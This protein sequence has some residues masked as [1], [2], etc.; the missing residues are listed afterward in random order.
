MK[1]KWC[2]ISW[3]LLG[4]YTGVD[5]IAILKPVDAET[6][7]AKIL[8]LNEIERPKTRASF[9]LGQA[10]S[11][12][13]R[14][15]VNPPLLTDD[16]SDDEDEEE[17]IVEGERTPT[18]S[19]P[20]Y[21][22]TSDEIQQQGSRSVTEVLRG[23]PGFAVNDTGF[24]ADIHTGLYYRGTTLNQ[25]VFLLNGRPIGSNVSTYHGAT[26]L[27][28]LLVGDIDRIELSSGTAST[29]YGSNAFGGVVDIITKDYEGPLKVNALAQFGSYGQQNYRAGI[30]GSINTLSYAFGYERF[31]ADND[32]RVPVGAAN[33]GPDGRLF[34]GDV[35]FENY[36]G[37]LALRID[38]RNT[39]SL[40]A[41]KI[42]SRKGLLYFGFPLQ[43][44]RLNHDA[45]NIGL[46]WKG[47]VGANNDSFI[48]AFLAFNR[49]YFDT[50]GPTRNIFFRE[51]QLDSR[52]LTG[53][54]EH[55]WQVAPALNLRYGVDLQSDFLKGNTLSNV[56]R[57]IRFNEVEERD[58]FNAALFLLNTWKITDTLQ[59]E[60]GLRQNFNTE[61]GN[62]LN[63]STGLRWDVAPT[64]ALRGSWVSVRRNPGLD[65]LYLYDT[66]HNWLPNPDLEPER[67]SAW[68]AGID[69]RLAPA[70]SAQLTYFGNRLKDRIG[71]VAGRWEN[72]ALVNTH[73]FE[74]A[75]RWN[76]TPQFSTFV[77]YTYT[78]ARIAA[79]P[80]KGLQLST[81][82]YS[83][84]QFG[85][86]YNSQGW[87]LNLYANYFSGARRALFAESG[88]ST[89]EFSPS[90]LSFD[91]SAQVPLFR[92]VSLLVYLENLGNR[93]YEKVNRIYQPGLTFRLGLNAS[94]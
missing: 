62:S 27:N 89:R 69:V 60:F 17:L 50:F 32:Y 49:D 45:Y 34:N 47:M 3:L 29:L 6:Q 24:G 39:L 54:I 15:S 48:T 36:Y 8:H 14:P 75:L 20:A 72:I 37:K 83:V 73:G 44:D 35:K 52:G 68:N 91:L 74:T 55:N 42:T 61:F 87:Q 26:D 4:C 16:P 7:P 13:A 5:A 51:G 56:P 12:P 71:I 43:R 80:E 31:Q 94:F 18:P 82:P 66:V 70:V 9:L 92:N 10:S 30:A 85:I 88:V 40:D 67:G 59:A 41:Y 22:I 58:R 81:I 21:V 90:W 2:I 11:E 23:L 86:G 33:R 79:G 46:T 77:N 53:R 28:S 78:D 84:G 1:L 65:Q 57:F 38:P 63:P 76:I 25:N 93:S 64:I 19:A